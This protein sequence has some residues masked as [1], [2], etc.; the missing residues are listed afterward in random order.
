MDKRRSPRYAISLN[1]L[2]HPSVGRSW[3][4]SI[5]DFCGGGM[6]LVE[7]DTLRRRT[8]PGITPNEI[9]GIHFSVPGTK[10]DQHFRLEGKIVRVMDSGVGIAFAKGMDEDALNALRGISERQPEAAGPSAAAAS[11]TGPARAGGKSAGLSQQPGEAAGIALADARKV[12]AGVRKEVAR[13]L[14]EMSSAFFG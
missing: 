3:L 2:V 12:I 9:V 4:C 6:L 13:I 7:Q 14:H 5:R 11:Q 1:A 10:G 8:L